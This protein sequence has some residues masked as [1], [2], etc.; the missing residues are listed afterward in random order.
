MWGVGI[1]VGCP[2]SYDLTSS[3][4]FNPEPSVGHP[5]HHCPLR[6]LAAKPEAPRVRSRAPVKF[7]VIY[8]LNSSKGDYIGD[9]Y[10]GYEGGTRSLDYS[11]GDLGF[12]LGG[13]G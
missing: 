4:D 2:E 3:H 8:S 13:P 1:R 10:T 12:L 6:G 9:Y 11:S 5:F 7:Q